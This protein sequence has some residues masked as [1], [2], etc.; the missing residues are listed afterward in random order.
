MATDLLSRLVVED[1]RPAILD[2]RLGFT[3]ECSE[4]D[5]LGWMH[6]HP[7]YGPYEPAVCVGCGTCTVMAQ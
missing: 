2:G 7:L 3:E 6:P 5:H 4:C 1:W